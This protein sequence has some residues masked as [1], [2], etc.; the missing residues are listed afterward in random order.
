MTWLELIWLPPIMLAIAVVLGTAGRNGFRVI[1]RSVWST[2]LV[3]TL[4]VIVVG[5]VIHAVARTFA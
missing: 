2:F 4:G 3:L 5:L 1:A